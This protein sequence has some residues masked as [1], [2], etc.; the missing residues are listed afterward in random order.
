MLRRKIDYGIDLGTTNSA[1]ARVDD[2][3]V[4]ILKSKDAQ[5]DTT[6]SC[7]YYDKKKNI[8]VGLKAF[9]AMEG[10]QKRALL[11]TASGQRNGD[12]NC[13]GEFKRAI[14]SDRQYA[15]SNMGKS[16]TPEE[17]S[18]EVLKKLRSNVDDEI[19]GAAVITVPAMFKQPQIDATQ[20]AAKLA[21]FEYCE[22]LQE[23]IAA[24]IAFG[25]KEGFWVVFDFGGGTFDA[26]L[27]KADEGIIK[28]I[29]TSGNNHLGG[30]DID[31]ALIDQL[32]IPHISK[33]FKVTKILS[34]PEAK[35]AL[36]DSLK[37]AA[38]SIKIQ[39]STAKE[40]HY[41]AGDPLGVDDAGE[42]IELDLRLS[43]DQFDK[44]VSPIVQQA[45]DLT[46]ELLQRNKIKGS[47]L[48][49]INLVGGPTFLPTIRRM[50]TEQVGPNINVSVDP[51]TAVAVGAAIF[52]STK[53]I[54][55]G[56]VARD[57]GRIQIGLNYQG[58]TVETEE[59]I[60]IKV[61]RS[62]SP[63]DTPASLSIEITRG[64]GLWSS[65]RTRLSGD[66]GILDIQLV[67]GK[68]NAFQLRVFDAEGT[69]WKCEPEHFSVAQ[70]FKIPEA[71]L[72]YNLCLHGFHS[73]DKKE[74]IIPIRGLEKNVPLPSK[75]KFIGRT[76]Q[77]LH[78]AKPGEIR[79]DIYESEEPFSRAF[80]VELQAVFRINAADLPQFL[81]ADSPVQV[82]V[83]VD[84]SRRL[85]VRA[86]FP[87][88]DEELIPKSDLKT[89]AIAEDDL[90]RDV[91]FA[92]E[93]VESLRNSPVNEEAVDAVTVELKQ[94]EKEFRANPTDADLRIKIADRMAGIWKKIDS[95]SG[96]A[97]WPLA[98]KQLDEAV[99]W[100]EEV[101]ERFGNEQTKRTLDEFRKM[102]TTIK[103][104]KDVSSARKLTDQIMGLRFSILRNQTAYWINCVQ[105]MDESFA[106]IQW[107][108]PGLARQLI[109]EAKQHI[110]GT[111]NRAKVEE[112]VR[113][114]WD[115]QV[116]PKDPLMS[117]VN[118]KL[119]KT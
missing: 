18:S 97:E 17:L 30:K 93:T 115:L 50:V 47:D 37:P 84:A 62:N 20:R 40:V 103:S 39:F 21:G 77:D 29:D 76:Q 63:G 61:D 38:E 55:A 16:F 116:E 112:Y 90:R 113:K 74:C 105:Y 107:R 65:A 1:I 10:E 8:H 7:V 57:R 89:S 56:L 79:F 43:L 119:L 101:Q 85:T 19:F 94:A 41:Y 49:S 91:T 96:T 87:S 48:R 108:T 110:A 59:S 28:V 95:L 100:V 81:P 32:L 104:T 71:T 114:L 31:N 12:R 58:T 64:D 70:G 6:P 23:P 118:L 92:C 45:I 68:T 26:A 46:R 2:G 53:D 78:P 117:H 106:E 80:S 111:P 60:G 72:P 83:E 102:A 54:P 52:A 15:S 3:V 22:L 99:E 66:V 86:Y 24:S 9:N 69:E 51:M 14:G 11:I 82:A 36:R 5:M 42:D 88:F 33:E 34:L 27:M 4:R 25:S 44:A 75:G 35:A 109:N 98:E 13:F 67:P 73:I